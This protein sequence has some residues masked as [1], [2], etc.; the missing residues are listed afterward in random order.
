MNEIS[1]NAF[2]QSAVNND[3][4]SLWQMI[5]GEVEVM[6]SP[7]NFIT[8]WNPT[9]LVEVHGE[10]LII[11][12]N[13]IFAKTQFEKKFSQIIKDI[14]KSHGYHA[15]KLE[16]ITSST[17]R[18]AK[19][20]DNDVVII[21]TNKT[22]PAAKTHFESKLNPNY[23]FDNFIVGSCNDLAHAAALAAAAKPG[24]KYN[25]IFIY[26]GVG[27]GKTHLIQAIGNEVL[28]QDES[29]KVLYATT[30]EFVNDFIYN[31]RTKTPD[32]FTKKYRELD[33]LIIDDFQFIAGK[34]KN[35]EAFFNTFNAL[36]QAEKQIIIAADK[37]PASI[38]T[39]PERLKSRLLMGMA[40]DVGLPDYETRI[41]IIEAKSANSSIDLPRETAEYL[42]ENIKT[43]VRELEGT[44]N[45]ILAYAEMQNIEP[46]R[47]FT[48]QI[49]ANSKLNRPKHITAKQIIEKTA[50]YFELKPA[51]ICSPARDKHIALPRQIAMYLLRS[52]LHMSYPKIANELGRKD[53]TTA[54]HSIDKI[55]REMKLD[56]IVREKVAAVREVIYA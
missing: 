40:I 9:K 44:L 2:N 56:I 7:S 30:E 14:L 19:H 39:L 8:F 33:V 50:K 13:N 49:L 32:E 51:E 41:A 53:H 22:K 17:K 12:V 18:N 10:S 21:R 23:N 52:E 35:T 11:E 20:N 42:A 45:Q 55:E 28:R 1:S 16:F 15:P 29:R 25:P 6:I 43:N 37:P 24:E 36:H 5:L 26:G 4:G 27:L 48:A 46:T 34:E 47:E 54:I 31:L 3:V 38:P